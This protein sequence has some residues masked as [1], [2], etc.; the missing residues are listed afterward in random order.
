MRK[1]DNATYVGDV[2]TIRYPRIPKEEVPVYDGMTCKLMGFKP[3]VAYALPHIPHLQ[4]LE[5]GVYRHIGDPVV[6]LETGKV[7]ELPLMYLQPHGYT[8]EDEI[9]KNYRYY[10][11]LTKFQW[12][13]D[14]PPIKC[15]VGDKILVAKHGV[16][17]NDV[18]ALVDDVSI[19]GTRVVIG[20]EHED[21]LLVVPQSEIIDVLELG[22]YSEE[23]RY[24]R[25][26]RTLHR[27]VRL[28]KPSMKY[29]DH[30]EDEGCERIDS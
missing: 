8:W 5:P 24:R 30:E 21:D 13:G 9:D 2:F 18:V 15:N 11:E 20:I 28:N 27:M 7:I 26:M 22:Q 23:S 29:I 19:Q 14:L 6:K 25:Q 17:D 12:M 16:L 10:N 1:Q 4:H 3:Q